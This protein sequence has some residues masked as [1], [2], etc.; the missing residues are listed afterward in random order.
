M[1]LFSQH[2]PT[3]PCLPS[4]FE[5]SSNFLNIQNLTPLPPLSHVLV[6]VLTPPL[7]EERM[8]PARGEEERA[9]AERE[10]EAS[11]KEV[12]AKAFFCVQ[13]LFFHHCRWKGGKAEMSL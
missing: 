11:R 3:P 4:R 6:L 9:E 1:N 8:Q 2:Q 5:A 13:H 12:A 7:T 10:L